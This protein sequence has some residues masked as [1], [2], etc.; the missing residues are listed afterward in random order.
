MFI[1]KSQAVKLAGSDSN[2]ARV[3]GITRQAVHQWRAR[4]PIPQKQA[5]KLVKIYGED[6]IKGLIK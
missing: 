4:H 5:M 1:Y 3:L 2:L 6:A